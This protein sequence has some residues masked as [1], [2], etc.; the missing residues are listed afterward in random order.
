[1]PLGAV[2]DVGEWH[3]KK[4]RGP[5]CDGEGRGDGQTARPTW[6]ASTSS[7]LRRGLLGG[8][9][10][11]G[12]LATSVAIGSAVS[13]FW[14]SCVLFGSTASQLTGL[15][16]PAVGR[17]GRAGRAGGC[18]RFARRCRYAG[19]QVGTAQSAHLTPTSGVASLHY[20][21]SLKPSANHRS[22]AGDERSER[23]GRNCGATAAR[24]Y[25]AESNVLIFSHADAYLSWCPHF[26][27]FCEGAHFVTFCPN[28]SVESDSRRC[29]RS[30]ARLKM[31]RHLAS[32]HN[33]GR[34]KNVS[35]ESR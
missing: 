29:A 7:R 2:G 14:P 10:L 12:G 34:N 11:C 33:D 22:R 21:K 3:L 16:P 26:A 20:R 27:H 8:N 6:S 25:R 28:R 19:C 15:A 17:P 30:G 31:A 35:R 13:G 32:P 5:S 18:P 1:M 9:G 24:D 23:P 4:T